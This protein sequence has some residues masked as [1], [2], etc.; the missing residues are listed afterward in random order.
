MAILMPALQRVKKQ[1]NTV[2]CLSLLKQWGLYFSM[3]AEENDGRFM[4]GFSGVSGGG[5]NRWC[6]ALGT[7]YKFDC[8]QTCCPNATKPWSNEDGSDNGIEGTF[9]GST[10]AWGYYSG[11]EKPLKGSYGIN[12]WCNNPDPGNSHSGKAEA[13]HWRGPNVRGAG[14]VPLFLGAQRYNIWPE[15]SDAPPDFDGQTWSGHGHMSRVCLNRHSDFVNSLFLDYS[16]RKVGL[17][18]LWTLKWHRNY[19]VGGPYTQAGGIGG[20]DWPDWM[21]YLKDY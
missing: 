18:E 16:A 6:K 8:S 4:Q 10:T 11:W 20:S 19:N 13:Y 21:R 3:Y 1:A 15:E 9:L 14:I 12:G 5:N 17:K 2:A 7:Y